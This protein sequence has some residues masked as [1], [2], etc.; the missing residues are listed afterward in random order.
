M[1]YF[2]RN[3]NIPQDKRREINGKILYLIDAGKTE[4]ANITQEDI[5]NA[6]TGDGGLHGLNRS[7]Y[8]N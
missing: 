3:E 1:K 8:N 5:Y 6:Y 4:D 7:D 2:Y